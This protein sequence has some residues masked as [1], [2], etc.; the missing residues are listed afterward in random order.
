MSDPFSAGVITNESD[1]LCWL[2]TNLDLTIPT[3]PITPDHQAPFDYIK[4]AF[5]ESDTPDCIVWANRGGG[6]TFLGAVATALDL[7]FKPG[8][9]VRILA[10]SLEQASRMHEHL[11]NVFE[12]PDF[13]SQLNGRITDRRITLQNGSR[14]ELLAQSQASVRGVRPHKLRCDEIELF[15]PDVWDAAQLTTR[16]AVLGGKLVRGAIEC[17]STMHRPHGLMSRLI[18]DPGNRRLFKWGLIDVLDNCGDEF[19]CSSCSLLPECKG[20]AQAGGRTPGH[21]S[22]PDARGMKSRVSLPIWNSEMLCDRPSRTD[23]VIPEFDRAIHTIDT[24]PWKTH[25]ELWLGGMDFGFRSPTVFLWAAV[26]DGCLYIVD[27]HYERGLTLD[28]H[29]KAIL[30]APYPK[31]AWVGADPAGRQRNSHTGFSSVALL[32]RAGL[33]VRTRPGAILDG[34]ALI[35][36]RLAPADKSPP[37]LLIHQRCTNLIESLERYHF[38]PE[39]PLSDEP[40]K[41]GPDHAVDSLRYLLSCL[42]APFETTLSGYL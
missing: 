9:Q 22:I 5:F 1:L 26:H 29:I 12:R 38:D 10:G 11:R 23:S 14:V 25:P 31:P 2:K 42:D 28:T 7:L 3:T 13:K 6:K 34:I 17:L 33:H 39:R 37:R 20:A 30:A 16:S 27:E 15:D 19:E 4:H 40:V 35:R 24:L 21:I 32:E 41:D 36:A 8:I 18:A